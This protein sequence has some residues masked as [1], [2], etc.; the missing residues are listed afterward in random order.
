[1]AYL[2]VGAAAA[3]LL[4]VVSCA[5]DQHADSYALSELAAS[6]ATAP[7]DG[8]RRIAQQDCTRPVTV[9]RGNLLCR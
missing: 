3:L 5:Y 8:S 1:M 7:M 4:L 9:D 6:E 2:K